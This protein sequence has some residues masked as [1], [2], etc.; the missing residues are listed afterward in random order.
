[1][2]SPQRPR[3]ARC[4]AVGLAAVWGLFQLGCTA[5]PATPAQPAFDTDVRPIFE[6]HCT[7]CHGAGPN[8]GSR[9]TTIVAGQGPSQPSG[10]CLTQYGDNPDADPYFGCLGGANTYATTGDLVKYIQPGYSQRMPPPPAPELD[11]W[12]MDVIEAWVAEP[13]PRI[14]SRSSNPDPAL[15]CPDSPDSLCM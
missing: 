2:R 6:A 12:E 5:Y 13:C 9:N 15:R 4:W 7:R 8:G 1:M 10:L 11:P 3:L 14:C